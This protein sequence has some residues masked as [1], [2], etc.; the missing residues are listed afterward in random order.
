M[1]SNLDWNPLKIEKTD[2]H[3]TNIGEGA[4]ARPKLAMI[5]VK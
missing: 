2:L 4:F 3:N 1:R 5:Q